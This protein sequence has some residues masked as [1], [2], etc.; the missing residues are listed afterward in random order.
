M[1]LTMGK[2][3]GALVA[4]LMLVAG[5][6]SGQTIAAGNGESS[7]AL[8]GTTLKVFTYR[9]TS[10]APRLVL[11]SF[12]GQGRQIAASEMAVNPLVDAGKLLRAR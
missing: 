6:A 11:A 3:L 12:H 7:A 4:A 1:V 5:A 10:C 2:G 8:L 9:P